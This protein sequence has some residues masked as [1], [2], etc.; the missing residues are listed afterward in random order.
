MICDLLTSCSQHEQ[1][2]W[3]NLPV[4]D[5]SSGFVVAGRERSAFG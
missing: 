5:V 2:M 1:L 3:N 4:A